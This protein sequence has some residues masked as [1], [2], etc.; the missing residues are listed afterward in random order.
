[1]PITDLLAGFLAVR[2]DPTFMIRYGAEIS[3]LGLM[4]S[5]LGVPLTVLQ[6]VS[7][8]RQGSSSAANPEQ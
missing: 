5:V 6:L 7:N 8:P 1:L 4:L 2:G 3:F